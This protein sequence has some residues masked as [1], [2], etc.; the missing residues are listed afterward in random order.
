MRW[1]NAFTQAVFAILLT[2][3][4][5]YPGG[6]MTKLLDDIKIVARGLAPIEGPQDSNELIGDLVTPG[7]TSPVGQ[8][9]TNLR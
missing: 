2:G 5:A 4:E 6:K 1:E 8:V 3:A 7:P 9:S